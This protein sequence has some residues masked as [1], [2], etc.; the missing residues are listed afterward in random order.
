MK[1]KFMSGERLERFGSNTATPLDVENLRSHFQTP[2]LSCLDALA[3]LGDEHLLQ[4]LAGSSGGLAAAE[5]N[6]MFEFAWRNAT[7]IGGKVKPAPQF[8]VISGS[9]T[10][11]RE[12]EVPVS[13]TRFLGSRW[14]A[15]AVG[16]VVVCT[17]SL[18][19][20]RTGSEFR[21]KGSAPPA[22]EIKAYVA[23][24]EGGRPTI[25]RGLVDGNSAEKSE[26]IVFRYRLDK[27]AWLYLLARSSKGVELVYRSKQRLNAGEHELAA[28]GKVLALSLRHETGDFELVAIA[29]PSPL[30]EQLFSELRGLETEVTRVLCD[31]CGESRLHIR[32]GVGP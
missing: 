18:T 17:A 19:L 1:C 10:L 2:C 21:D 30:E 11:D 26:H 24:V 3:D 9:K 20:F 5:Q 29:S 13:W 15:A 25:H 4:Q 31:R 8:S 16:V 27:P 28:N 7:A 32:V 14:L 22:I 12:K 6:E 23:R